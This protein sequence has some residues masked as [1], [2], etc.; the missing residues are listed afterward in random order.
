MASTAGFAPLSSRFIWE[1][2]TSPTTSQLHLGSEAGSHQELLFSTTV[3]QAKLL[4]CTWYS[5]QA[6]FAL[7]HTGLEV[8]EIQ[9]FTNEH[10]RITDSHSISATTGHLSGWGKE[11]TEAALFRAEC[12]IPVTKQPYNKETNAL[13]ILRGWKRH[14]HKCGVCQKGTEMIISPK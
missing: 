1:G 6:L 8:R 12:Q 3:I 4:I 2:R 9:G 13:S 10:V 14:N 5:R 7:L 11:G